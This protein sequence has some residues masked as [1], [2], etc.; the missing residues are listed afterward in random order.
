MSERSRR[1][2]IVDD[3]ETFLMYLSILLRRMGFDIIPAD[4]G[5]TALKLLRVLMPD[6]EAY[7]R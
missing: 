1:I 7:K 5:I 2:L 3:S 4:N 6:I